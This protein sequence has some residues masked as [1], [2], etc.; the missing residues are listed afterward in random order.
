MI[1]EWMQIKRVWQELS[2]TV[3]QI[4]NQIVQLSINFHRIVLLNLRK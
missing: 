1:L 3:D 2:S 4:C